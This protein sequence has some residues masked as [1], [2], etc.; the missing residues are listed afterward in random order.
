MTDAEKGNALPE[1]ESVYVDL[2]KTM[3][4]HDLKYTPYL[5]K[6]LFTLEEATICVELPAPAEQ[7]AKKLGLDTQAVEK[8]IKKLV[9]E[10]KILQTQKGPKPFSSSAQLGD[11]LLANPATDKYIDD[12]YHEIEMRWF[13]EPEFVNKGTEMV[14]QMRVDGKPICRVVPRWKAIKDIPGVMPSEDMRE[15]LKAYDKLNTTRCFCR[16]G[17]NKP[18]CAVGDRKCADPLDGFCI[19]FGNIAEYYGDIMGFAPYRSAE[20]ILKHL[21]KLDDKPTY[22][23]APNDRDTRFICNCCDCCLVA[24]PFRVHPKYT[25]KD[26]LSPS[27]FLCLVDDGTCTGCESCVTLCPFQAIEMKEGKAAIDEE[28]CMGCGV[29]VINCPPDAMKLKIVRPA[30]HIPVGGAQ[31]VDSV[32]LE[33]RK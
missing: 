28:K 5:Y 29:C 30:E 32:I 11:I 23:M 3:V 33:T 24:L 27:R 7:I 26:V 19:H 16:T 15:V 9:K 22:H 13:S 1:I 14:M 25:I 20:D 31:L 10:G 17:M 12:E 4:D 21:D 8:T 2:A 18:D 6:K